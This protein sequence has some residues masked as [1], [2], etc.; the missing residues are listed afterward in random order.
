MFKLIL[1]I[2]IDGVL[3]PLIKKIGILSNYDF[4]YE[5]ETSVMAAMSLISNVTSMGIA[6]PSKSFKSDR[7]I[8]DNFVFDICEFSELFAVS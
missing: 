5:Q 4:I 2:R 1:Q 3:S 7:I 6:F 8:V